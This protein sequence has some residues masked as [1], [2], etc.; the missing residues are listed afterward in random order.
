MR[1]LVLA[2]TL[3]FG[4]MSV[5]WA[6]K[7]TKAYDFFSVEVAN[8]KGELGFTTLGAIND[9]REITGGFTVG[10]A[11]GFLMTHSGEISRIGCPNAIFTALLGI[12]NS[13]AMAGS[14]YDGVNHAFFRNRFGHFALIDVPDALI[15][16]GR[17]L[18]DMN[19]VVGYFRDKTGAQHGFLWDN[20]TITIFDLPHLQNVIPYPMGINNRGEIV[21]SYAESPC[22][23]NE[24]GFLLSRGSLTMIDFPSAKAT[25]PSGINDH[26]HIVGVYAETDTKHH[27]FLLGDGGFTT[28]DV[29][30]PG[31]NFTEAY[32]INN[33]GEVVGRYL[34]QNPI[35]NFGFIAVP[36]N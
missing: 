33:R 8:A 6:Q 18:N 12:N 26:G 35:Y 32:G 5:A 25:L 11:Q 29:S 10:E 15:T 16:Q 19:Q 28:I 22:N 27:G 30:F 9:H 36:R 4:S 17:G 20:G 23:C 2:L 7:P 31:I 3:G 1:V 34:Q 13:G 21:G 24:R 14:C